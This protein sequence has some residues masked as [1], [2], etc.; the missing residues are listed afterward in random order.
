MRAQAEETTTLVTATARA[1]VLMARSLNASETLAD[2]VHVL[3][4]DVSDWAAIHLVAEHGGI[5]RAAFIHRDP[6]IQ[7][8]IDRVQQTFAVNQNPNH[9]PARVIRTG[10]SSFAAR[11]S[12][13]A[14]AGARDNFAEYGNLLD[15]MIGGSMISVPLR[16]R[17]ATIGSLTFGRNRRQAYTRAHLTWAEDLG[18]RLGLSI[19]N[20]RLYSEARQLFEQTVTANYVSTP[21]GRI[22]AA[23]QTF[24]DL[25]GFQSPDEVLKHPAHDF[26]VNP[27]E[28]ERGLVALARDGRLVGYESTIR[29]RDGTLLSIAENAVGTFDERGELVK[30][31]GYVLDRSNVKNLEEQLRQSQRLEAVGQ[32]AGGIAHDFNNLL[33]VIIGCAD[34]MKDAHHPSAIEGHD[35]LEELM[36]AAKRAAGLTQQLLAFGRRQVLLPHVLDL[37]E[38]L[39]SVH[40]MLRRLVR[41]NIVLTLNLDPDI[42]PVRVDPGQLDQV[43]VN[44]VVNAGD[45]MPNGG[46]VTL[47]TANITVTDAHVMEHPFLKPGAYASVVVADSG[48][49]MDHETRARAFE[50]FFTTKPIGK[51]TGLGLST[52]YG[53]VKQ[54][55]GYVWIDS[56][57][58]RGTTVTVCLP[59]A[60]AD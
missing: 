29:R 22:L 50:P 35:P 43:V 47:S 56:A 7:A 39:R 45:A 2:V 54:S 33:T 49:G 40:G 18:H 17:G 42:A 38:S 31:T 13:E 11:L 15:T 4:P 8:E 25:L 1:G 24:A 32:L 5:A 6:A 20:A 27:D 59:I 30:I 51:G 23:N 46:S 14:L 41:E 52:V 21:D 60:T 53:I 12:R 58:G 44:L 10:Q 9:G 37:N 19:E 34:L 3:V 57:S 48:A 36:K 26:Y 16:S 28:R 55:G